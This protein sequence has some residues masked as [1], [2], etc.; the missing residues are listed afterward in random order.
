[1][2][3]FISSFYAPFSMMTHDVASSLLLLTAGSS[4]LLPADNLLFFSFTSSFKSLH[5]SV[6]Q[7]E[8]SITQK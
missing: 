6:K 1:M 7:G 4:A 8:I 2:F 3:V 5:L